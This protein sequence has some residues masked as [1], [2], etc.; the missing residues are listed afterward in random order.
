MRGGKIALLVVGAVVG[1]VAIGL[2]VGGA[3]LLYVHGTQRDD[4]GYYRTDTKPLSTSTYA[5]TSEHIDLGAQGDED[6]APL[7]N[8]GTVELRAARADGGDVFVGI[9]DA[10]DVDRFLA[11][12]AHAEVEEISYDPYRPSYSVRGG[13]SA[14]GAPGAQTFWVAAASGPEGQS[15]KWEIESGDWAV[16]VMNADGSRGVV[17]DASVGVKTGVLLPIGIGLLAAGMAA[18]GLAVLM[19]ILGARSSASGETAGGAS[20]PAAVSAAGSYPARLEGRLDAG[21]SRGL[22]LVKWFLAIPHVIV[23]SFLWA[24]LMFTTFAAGVAILFTGRYPRTLFDFAVG[25]M[26]WTWRVTFYAFTLGT[27]RYPPFSLVPDPS[28]PADFSVDYPESLSRGLVLVKWW[29]LAIPHYVIVGV[30]GSGLWWSWSFGRGDDGGGGVIG[31]GLIGLLVLVAAV[32]LLF[33]GRY[34]QPLFDFVMGMQR[35]TYR[36]FAYAG[37][38]RDEYPPFRLDTGGSDPGTVVVLPEGGPDAGGV[39]SDQSDELV[40]V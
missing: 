24:A 22:W 11:R 23:L 29:L 21:L 8:I 4:A 1:L 28:Y 30:F 12:S 37:L 19:M 20:V 31:A 27:D 10:V 6:W 18:A 33:T 5:L 9:A 26:R 16:V 32:I 35:W 14:P 2:V 7:D 36:V 38:L 40:G 17:V 3:G 25:V 39:G 34:P 15:L 13:E